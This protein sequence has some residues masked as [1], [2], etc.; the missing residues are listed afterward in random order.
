MCND[1]QRSVMH[2]TTTCHNHACVPCVRHAT[3]AVLRQRPAACSKACN[4]QPVFSCRSAVASATTSC[5][6]PLLSFSSAVALCKRFRNPSTCLPP[7][8]RTHHSRRRGT[9][10]FGQE[11]ATYSPQPVV[12]GMVA[13][14]AGSSSGSIVGS[15][16]RTLRRHR[17]TAHGGA[18]GGRGGG[19]SGALSPAGKACVGHAASTHTS[20]KTHA[21]HVAARMFGVGA[22]LGF[23]SHVRKMGPGMHCAM[24]CSRRLPPPNREL[25]IGTHI[26]QIS[27]SSNPE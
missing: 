13:R 23:L 3:A 6:L 10:A 25:K 17:H 19:W 20:T 24:H 5:T 21:A 11:P 26:L 8:T 4:N 12:I 15:A 22:I 27:L 16:A 14:L 9:V 7:V 2:A 1:L 18:H